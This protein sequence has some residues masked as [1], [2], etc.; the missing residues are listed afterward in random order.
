M[1]ASATLG[2]A[3][4]TFDEA[5]GIGSVKFNVVARSRN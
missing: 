1:V 5:Q 2:R 3:R 4:T